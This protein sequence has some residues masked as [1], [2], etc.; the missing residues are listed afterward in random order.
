[1]LGS[2]STFS[3][4]RNEFAGRFGEMPAVSFLEGQVK[5]TKADAIG[6]ILHDRHLYATRIGNHDWLWDK[7]VRVAADDGVDAFH[8]GG[9]LLVQVSADMG[10]GDEDVALLARNGHPAFRGVDGI[11]DRPA[12]RLRVVFAA[13]RG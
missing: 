6:A 12:F 2:S 10:D 3:I 1:M 4:D 13:G 5:A 11:A 9:Q 8:L 7:C